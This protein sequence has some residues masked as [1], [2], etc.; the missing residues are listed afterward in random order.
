MTSIIRL[1]FSPAG[2]AKR[3][4]YFLGIVIAAILLV[5]SILISPVV[6]RTFEIYD[7]YVFLL[8]L[9]DFVI[10]AKYGYYFPFPWV[11]LFLLAAYSL[12]VL[13]IKRLRALGRSPWWVVLSPIFHWWIVPLFLAALPLRRKKTEGKVAAN[14]ATVSPTGEAGKAASEMETTQPPT[15]GASKDEQGVN[16]PMNK[17]E[18]NSRPPPNAGASLFSDILF[19][20]TG[21][22]KRLAIRLPWYGKA[23]IIVFPV[24][25]YF[26]YPYYEEWRIWDQEFETQVYNMTDERLGSFRSVRYDTSVRIGVSGVWPNSESDAQGDYTNERMVLVRWYFSTKDQGR[27]DLLNIY[28]EEKCGQLFGHTVCQREKV[29]V[30][31]TCYFRTVEL[32]PRK[33]GENVLLIGVY[34]KSVLRIRWSN[35]GFIPNNIRDSGGRHDDAWKYGLVP[36]SSTW[37]TKDSNGRWKLTTWNEAEDGPKID[38]LGQ[39]A[40]VTVKADSMKTCED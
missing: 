13:Q 30:P 38:A 34:D 37:Q 4:P 6:Q 32:P 8:A 20:A 3:L 33:K 40:W 36:L 24:A 11:L 21:V 19:F 2:T 29:K 18:S 35:D 9:W 7:H 23:L 27:T 22:A 14:E 31:I 12:T 10:F 26:A 39:G 28:G 17:K 25:A 16:E 15:S 1:L 5:S